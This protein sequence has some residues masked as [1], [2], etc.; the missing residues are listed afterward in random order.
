[1]NDLKLQEDLKKL[2]REVKEIAA[3]D[4]EAREQLDLLISDIERR[5]QMPS[6]ANHHKNLLQG[7]KDAIG[8]FESE[9]PRATA[10]LNDIMTTLGNVGI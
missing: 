8:R 5:I 1:M 2:R 9:H 4:D 10:I 3:G 7:I 6:D